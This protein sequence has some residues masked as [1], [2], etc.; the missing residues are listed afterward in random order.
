VYRTRAVKN[1]TF[2]TGRQ[3]H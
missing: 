3:I 2:L 1:S